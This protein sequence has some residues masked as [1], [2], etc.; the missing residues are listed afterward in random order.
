[1]NGIEKL[2]P[3]LKERRGEKGLRTIAR[4]IGVSAATISRIERGKKPD[5]DSFRKICLWLEVDPGDILGYW[6]TPEILGFSTPGAK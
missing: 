6:D 4:E 3:L 2:G 5:I 1:M